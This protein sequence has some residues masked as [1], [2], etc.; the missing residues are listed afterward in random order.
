ME[1]LESA[2]SRA[3]DLLLLLE[4]GMVAA[5]EIPPVENSIQLL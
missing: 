4:A 5:G 2:K 1:A 3:G